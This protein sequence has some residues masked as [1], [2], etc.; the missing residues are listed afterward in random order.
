MSSLDIKLSAVENIRHIAHLY[1]QDADFTESLC[2]YLTG[3]DSSF[4]LPLGL[5]S[6]TFRARFS[7]AVT[8]ALPF[9]IYVIDDNLPRSNDVEFMQRALPVFQHRIAQATVIVVSS[10]PSVL[11]LLCREFA[12]LTKGSLTCFDTLDKAGE[13]FDYAA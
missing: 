12:V 3:T 7:L 6:S 2:R 1:Q 5:C 13:V 4:K 11:Q 10:K 8:Y 9:D